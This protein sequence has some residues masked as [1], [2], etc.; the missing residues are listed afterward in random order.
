[1]KFKIDMLELIWNIQ[2]LLEIKPTIL[3][4]D[5]DIDNC[6]IH[7]YISDAG[8]RIFSRV[9]KSKEYAS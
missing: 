5:L 1:M 6:V 9:Q 2:W 7:V 3:L 4:K 8:R